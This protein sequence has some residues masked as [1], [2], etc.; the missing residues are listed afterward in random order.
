MVF[1]FKLIGSS[2]VY[3]IYHCDVLL[4]QLNSIIMVF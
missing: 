2:L 1:Y 4:K 3:S